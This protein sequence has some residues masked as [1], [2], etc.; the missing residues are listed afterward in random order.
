[1]TEKDKFDEFLEE[2]ESDIRQERFLKLWNAYGKQITTGITVILAGLVAYTLWSN[3]KTKEHQ[4]N[5]Q[6][7]IKA[8]ELVIEGNTS[9]A[10][11]VLKEIKND[12]TY[13]ALGKFME[14]A[15]LSEKT[16]SEGTSA[17]KAIALYDQLS[18]NPNIEQLWRHVATLQSIRL[19]FSQDQK[20]GP[21]LLPLLDPLVA[22]G[23]PIRALAL[24]QK[25]YMLHTMGKSA[26]AAEQFVKII[27]MKEAPDAVAKRARIMSE[28]LASRTRSE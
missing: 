16:D 10:L 2:V 14:A 21:D 25:G 19:K 15:L 6:Y 3:Y 22:E 4:K 9:Q 24:E 23:A 7:F 12:A 5:A 27:Q 17:Q 8:Q 18:K 28:K 1:M 20:L 13:S 11:S 26:E